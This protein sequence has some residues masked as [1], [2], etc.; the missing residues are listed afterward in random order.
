MDMTAT[1]L[2]GTETDSDDA[3]WNDRKTEQ[4]R[5]KIHENERENYEEYYDRNCANFRGI[6][7]LAKGMNIFLQNDNKICREW[8]HIPTPSG[9]SITIGCDSEDIE[10]N[11]SFLG[12]LFREVDMNGYSPS[13]SNCLYELTIEACAYYVASYLLHFT[14]LLRENLHRCAADADYQVI[15]LFATLKPSARGLELHDWYNKNSP[16]CIAVIADCIELGKDLLYNNE[17]ERLTL[18]QTA[19]FWRN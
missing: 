14:R 16:G 17:M 8:H 9:L 7:L 2:G 3:G 12:K 15:Q 1:M 13:V 5:R 18:A 4:K 10:I 11:S 6:V 19:D